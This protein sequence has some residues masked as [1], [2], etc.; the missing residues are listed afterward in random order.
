MAKIDSVNYQ[1]II[2]GSGQGGNPLALDLARA[3]WKTALVEKEKVGGS[4][5]NYGCTPTKTMVAGARVAYLVG[6][7]KEYGVESSGIN[8]DM[9]TVRDRKRKMVD[10]FR[11]GSEKKIE[12]SENL[13][14]Y[15]GEARF[16][17]ARE[18]EVRMTDGNSRNMRADKIFI[19]T[20]SRSAIPNID[21]LDNVPFLDST[22]IMELD[23]VPDHL[24]I[25]GG[26]YIGLEFGQM[27]RRFG[28]K[29][30]IIHR[31][32]QLLSREDE[33]IADEVLKILKEDAIDVLLNAKPAN[34]KRPNRDK[35]SISINSPDGDKTIDGSHLLIAAGR[36]P[37]T[38]R[39]NLDSAG[40]EYDNKGYIK[41][42][43]RLETNVDGVYVIGDIKGGPAFTHISYDD[44]RV[45][46]ANILDGKNVSV[47]N[48]LVPY[49]VFIDPQL[50]RVGLS[51]KQAKEMG[52]NYKIAKIP[53]SYVPRA[54]EMSESRG[55]MKAVVD[56]DTRKILGCAVLGIEGGEI[57]NMI[58]VAMMGNLPYT[59][60]RDAVFAHPTLGESLNTLFASIDN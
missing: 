49:T 11:S 8:I 27:F 58:Q 52:Y 44:Y 14:Y 15:H 6:R 55:I 45:L 38:D 17:G 36:V 54:L 43:N 13:D 24:I 57:M 26:G 18:I 41:S 3:G 56:M 30:T 46:K 48:R 9:K 16:T 1:A 2:I 29:V 25:I 4:C 5:I 39:L 28:S 53:M 31:G 20:G 10:S 50:G 23:I 21:G 42:N 34:V 51:E 7:G 12:N 47:D 35:I 60:L 33:D 19:D 32:N 40:I 37:N 22:S 59:V